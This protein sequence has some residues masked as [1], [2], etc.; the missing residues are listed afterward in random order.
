MQGKKIIVVGSPG[1]GKSSFARKLRD[2]TGIPLYYL[3][4]L[5][6]RSDRTTA[7]REEFDAALREILWREEWI[8]DGNY[9]R[10]LPLRFEACTDVFF[11]DLP[12]EL[13]LAGAAARVGQ[14]RED[15]PWVETEFDEAFRRYILDFPR[16][17]LPALRELS[18][19]FRDTR[20]I[21]V[22]RSREE[23]DAFL[24]GL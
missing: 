12:V 10:T 24:A 18:E 16:D 2:K 7:G 14:A 11:F 1:A 19:R 13:C 23:A 9:Q 15:M 4:L 6:H 8:I 17:Q 21:T 20:R 22:F 5:F 3:D